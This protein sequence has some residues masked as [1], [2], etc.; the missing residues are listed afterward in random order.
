MS[1][2]VEQRLPIYVDLDG[3]LT[4]SDLLIESFLAF[5]KKHPLRMF[6]TPL[7]LLKGKAYLKMRLAAEVDIAVD[8]LPYN[9]ALLEYLQQQR[10]AGRDV[11]LATASN[12]KYASQVAAHH[13][14]FSGYIAS[15]EKRNLSGSRK[16]EVIAQQVGEGGFSYVGNS[17]KDIPIWRHARE[18][19]LVEGEPGLQKELKRAKIAPAKVFTKPTK[20]SL[21]LRALRPHQWAK[22]ALIFLPA[23][24]A[25]DFSAHTLTVSLAAFI[26]FS[27]CASSVYLLNDLLDLEVDRLHPRKKSRPFASGLVDMRYGLAMIPLLLL[28]SFMVAASLAADFLY[29]LLIYYAATLSYSLGLKKFALVDVMLLS[30]LYTI[31]VVGGAMAADIPLSY[32]IMAF[33]MFIF[34][35][36]ALVKR[37]AEL[38][39]M[40]LM[41][42]SSVSGRG[43][44]VSDLEYLHSM[45]IASGYLSV[46]VL[47]LYIHSDEIRNLYHSPDVMFA[48]IPMIMY[49]VS[50]MWLKAGR[51]EMDDDP[52]VFSI[53]DRQSQIVMVC[54]VA[55][56]L[57]AAT[58]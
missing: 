20:P 2:S 47:A 39:T 27:L 29:V 4:H 10:D 5:V 13:K 24:A 11:F 45:G 1:E 28:A 3:S 16:F 7:W 23:F 56:T 15:D 25:H 54:I 58:H 26:A 42:R 55:V 31:R 40:R 38:N 41:E 51:G 43:Y 14:F 46:L 33:S 9:D 22:N 8:L 36:L 34:I 18:V 35:S 52:L 44:M 12:K 30:G 32:W 57:L 19:L 17:R 21:Y 6:L 50:R 37:C 53:K 49:W 48:V